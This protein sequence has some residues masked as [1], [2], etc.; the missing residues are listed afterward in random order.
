[1]DNK[2]LINEVLENLLCSE[3]NCPHGIFP[4]CGQ[5][6]ENCPYTLEK[7]LAHENEDMMKMILNKNK[8]DNDNGDIEFEVLEDIDAKICEKCIVTKRVINMFDA[9]NVRV[10]N[11]KE[12]EDVYV[13]SYEHEN[14]KK[15]I[16]C[17]K[18]IDFCEY[19]KKGIVK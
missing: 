18:N 1:V 5:N 7:M 4:A 3:L 14:K 16:V 2:N 19:Y 17:N 11:I 13:V 9:E 6:A 10:T 12:I 8:E 15:T